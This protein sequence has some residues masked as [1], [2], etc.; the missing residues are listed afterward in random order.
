MDVQELQA[1]QAKFK[2]G[3]GKLKELSACLGRMRK[4]TGLEIVTDPIDEKAGELPFW[5][6]GTRYFVRVRLTDRSIGLLSAGFAV[7][8]STCNRYQTYSERDSANRGS[9]PALQ[10]SRR[11]CSCQ[12]A[13]SG[14]RTMGRE[15]KLSSGRFH[16]L[17]T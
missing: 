9:R 17:V 13:A 12:Y 14:N 5:F 10:V 7:T 3:L 16:A 11:S 2:Q 8:P 1:M 6:A 15:N 4:R